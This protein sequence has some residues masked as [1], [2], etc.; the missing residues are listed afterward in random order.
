MAKHSKAKR[1]SKG[2]GPGKIKRRQTI[3]VPHKSRRKQ[4]KVA[5]SV[6]RQRKTVTAR[7]KSQHKKRSTK[8]DRRL[9]LAVREINRGRSLTATARSLGISSK[10]LQQQLK[11]KRLIKRKGGRWVSTDNRLRRIPVMS[12]GRFRVLTV[13]GP[14]AASLVGK[15]HSAVGKFLRTNDIQLLKPFSGQS[16]SIANGRR[17]VLETDPNVLH[18]IAAMDSPPFHEIYDIVAPT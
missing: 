15:H 9:E 11:R 8:S 17:F 6:S 2:K 3:K 4:R 13:R 1:R 16:V 18:R 14:K 12:G 10:S 5:R 7:Q